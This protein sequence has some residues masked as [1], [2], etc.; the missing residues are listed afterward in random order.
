[1]D[2]A[3][4]IQIITVVGAVVKEAVEL[5]PTVIKTVEDAKPFAE[6]IVNTILGKEVTVADLTA[7]EAQI[8][9]LSA[10][11]QEPLPPEQPD[12]V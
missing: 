7:L 4:V 11:L 6:A 9:A 1:M 3:T 12:D 2:P 10:Q 5:G 8:A